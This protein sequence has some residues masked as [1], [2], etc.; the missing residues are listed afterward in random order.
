MFGLDAQRRVPVD[1]SLDFLTGVG[2]QHVDG[3]LLGGLPGLDSQSVAAS[4]SGNVAGD[5][6]LDLLQ[7]FRFLCRCTQGSRCCSDQTVH[8]TLN[9]QA[10]QI[11]AA[12]GDEQGNRVFRLLVLA[13][14]SAVKSAMDSDLSSG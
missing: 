9:M 1:T 7:I 3:A 5:E 4:E 11:G 14:V 6:G 8:T 2:L 12:A 13:R 10:V